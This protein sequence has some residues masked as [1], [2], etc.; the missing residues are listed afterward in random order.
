MQLIWST[1]VTHYSPCH[2]SDIITVVR[3]LWVITLA[4]ISLL[5]SQ[6][7]QAKFL[8]ILIG[9]TMN[10]LDN[11]IHRKT[12]FFI[13]LMLTFQLRLKS[14]RPKSERR[15]AIRQTVPKKTSVEVETSNINL[16]KKVVFLWI[17]LSN[18]QAK[19]FLWNCCR[20]IWILSLYTVKW[21]Y[22][23]AIPLG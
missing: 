15:T 11:E 21:L 8:N 6:E 23:G 18:V 4:H 2:C 20:P 22:L 7:L 3:W 5:S 17:S 13:R 1:L 9:W 19:L 16:I 14:V 12:T 10:S